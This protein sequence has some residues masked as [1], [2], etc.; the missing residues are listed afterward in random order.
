MIDCSSIDHCIRDLFSSVCPFTVR[1][2]TREDTVLA[3]LASLR[4]LQSPLLHS[5]HLYLVIIQSKT[6]R[7]EISFHTIRG[8]A[9]RG[10]R[11][12]CSSQFTFCSLASF[13]VIQPIF[14]LLLLLLL[15]QSFPICSLVL[16]STYKA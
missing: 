3:V 11:T 10:F 8:P 7:I 1:S 4:F 6:V 9:D 2:F 16:L 15:L 5:T 12:F 13:L 14:F